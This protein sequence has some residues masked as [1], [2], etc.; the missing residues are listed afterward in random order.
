MTQADLG[1]IHRLDRGTGGT[2]LLLLHGTG[3]DEDDLLSLGRAVA[4]EATLLSPRGQVVE[5]GMPR[6]FKRLA[7]GVFDVPDLIARSADLGRFVSSAADE[8]DLDPGRVYALGYSNGANIAA[9]MLLLHPEILAGAALLHAMVPL[10]PAQPPDL[11]GKPVLIT[12]GR[13]DPI[14]PGEQTEALA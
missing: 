6:F 7:M 11:T 9:A 13:R 10:E 3:G 12:G 1:F 2:T 8:Y 5:G 4:P 14:I